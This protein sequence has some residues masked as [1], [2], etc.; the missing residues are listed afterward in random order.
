MKTVSQC[1]LCG[2]DKRKH[3]FPYSVTFIERVYSYYR[4]QQCFAVYIDPIPDASVFTEIY[5]KNNYH[6]NHYHSQDLT[7][8]YSSVAL[9]SDYA[10]HSDHILDY[11]CGAGHFLRCLRS[12]GFHARGVE[13]DTE[14]ALAASTFSGCEVIPLKNTPLSSLTGHY[15][16]IHLGDVLEHLPSPVTTLHS[17]LSLLKPGGILFVEGPLEANLSPVYLSARLYGFL[18]N[19]FLRNAPGPGIPAHLF[20][21]SDFSQKYFFTHNFPSLS[22]LSWHVSESGWPYKNSGFIKNLIAETAVSIGG[23]RI[24][25]FV[26]GNRFQAF[27]RYN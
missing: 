16:L 25:P 19:T 12:Q 21:T 6:D 10:S 13:F 18:K 1:P 26:F 15:D 22:L 8:Y 20:I 7:A 14:A 4:C 23:R 2:S 5:S 11:G 17:I 27:F 3:S 9:M 24:G